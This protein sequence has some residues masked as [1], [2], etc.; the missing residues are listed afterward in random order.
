MQELQ[1]IDNLHAFVK[2]DRKG[3]LNINAQTFNEYLVFALN[4][5][6]H[7]LNTD[8]NEHFVISINHDEWYISLPFFDGVSEVENG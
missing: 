6:C 1:V 5:E 3:E 8:T 7:I 4:S 2:N